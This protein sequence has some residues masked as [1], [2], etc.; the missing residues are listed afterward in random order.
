MAILCSWIRRQLTAHADDELSG[1]AARLVRRHLAGCRG[2][3]AERAAIGRSVAD[4]RELL[5]AAAGEADV[6]AD[7]LWSGVRRRLAAEPPRDAIRKPAV[8]LVL[9]SAGAAAVL[10]VAAR[11][12]DPLWISVGL[13]DPP[14]KLAEEPELFVDYTLFEHLEAI[15]N[16]DTPAR[17]PGPGGGL[18][19]RG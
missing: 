4:Q 12:L 14:R 6:D 1:A 11:L 5:R 10:L 16:L 9:A 8:R 19:S 3:V 15:E 7:L 18:R 13:E 17:S 2:C